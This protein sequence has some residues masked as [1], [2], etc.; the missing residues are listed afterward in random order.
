MGKILEACSVQ[1]HPEQT[2]ISGKGIEYRVS[3]KCPEVV[4][5]IG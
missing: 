1:F 2:G 5:L 4:H 3:V